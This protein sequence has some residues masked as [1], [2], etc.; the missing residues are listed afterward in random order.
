MSEYT[1]EKDADGIV[2]ATFD[3][4]DKA[5]NTMTMAW[6]DAMFELIERLKAEQGLTGVVLTSAKKTFFAGGDLEDI[7]ANDMSPQELMD[8]IERNK[9]PFRL[10]EKL[11]VPVVAAINGAALGG[12]YEMCLACN[13]RIVVNHPKAVVGL[14]EVQ[15][16]LLPGAGGVVRLTAKL[17]LEKALPLLLE[18]KQL[19]PT[20]ALELGL[21]EQVVD[22][23]DALIPAAKAWVKANPEAHVQPWDQ[24]GFSYPGGG[25]DAPNVRMAATMAPTMLFNKTRGLMP[26]PEKIVDIAVNSMR[27]GFDSALRAESRGIVALIPTPECKAA[28][29]TFFFGIQAVKSGA[30]RPEGSEFRFESTAVLGAGMMGAGIAWINAFKGIHTV[31]T[32]I[33]IENAEQGKTNAETLA[34]KL[35]ARKRITEAEK[36]KLLGLIQP[37]EDHRDLEGVEIII[38]AVSEDINIKEQVIGATFGRLS[39]TGFYASNTSSLPISVLA[40]FCPD[41]S[42]FIGL[43]F[44]SP[45]DKMKIV[46]IICGAKTS[47]ETLRKAYDYVAKI[48]YLPIVV[49]DARGFFTSRVFATY[50]DEGLQLLQDGVAPIEIERA[51]WKVG[52]PV[53]PLAVHDEVSMELTRKAFVTHQELDQRLGEE[54]AFGQHNTATQRIG[55]MMCEMGRRGRNWDG[56]GFY[57][58]HADG[59]KS[60]WKGLDQFMIEDRGV[61]LSDAMDRLMYRQAIETLRC[62]DEGVLNT[63]VEGNV[64]SIFAIGFPAHTGGALQFIK[65]IGPATFK[66]RA[67]ELAAQYG[68]RFSVTHAQLGRLRG[69]LKEAA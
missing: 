40:E 23:L 35:I 12:G 21:V 16:G 68:E 65:G 7:L 50:L 17:G 67:D 9:A 11:P 26:A 41:P 33:R 20:A 31:L 47:T 19:R 42:R 3:A 34:N 4:S 30:I 39:T 57:D 14:P 27:M 10:L 58:Y 29:S 32:D 2:T 1:Y 44:F 24:K 8:Y 22:T 43:H 55:T 15:L 59:S 38:E 5:A 63:E 61:S 52:M 36:N 54:S 53:G 69:I 49:N 66:A 46:E 6:L 45:V 60:L 13:H 62:L 56:A 18:G 51:G 25:A 28:I 48:G 37:S 64:G